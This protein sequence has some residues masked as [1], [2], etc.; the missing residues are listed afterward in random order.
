MLTLAVELFNISNTGRILEVRPD[1]SS[2]GQGV[3]FWSRK[4]EVWIRRPVL[5]GWMR[6]A[7]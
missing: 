4:C 6:V 7:H 2:Q 1:L 3:Q 5:G